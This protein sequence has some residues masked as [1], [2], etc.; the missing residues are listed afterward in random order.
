MSE[1]LFKVL[2]VLASSCEKI[3]NVEEEAGGF[4]SCLVPR[5]RVIKRSVF[6]LD[7]HEN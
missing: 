4:N 6:V 7:S 1:L 3:E 2:E 5:R